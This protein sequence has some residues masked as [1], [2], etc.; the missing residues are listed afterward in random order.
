MIILKLLVP[1]KNKIKITQA[2]VDAL[3]RKYQ[4]QSTRIEALKKLASRTAFELD[5][6]KD[7]VERSKPVFERM[8]GKVRKRN[9]KYRA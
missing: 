2:E 4:D 5:D 3:N 8:I 7:R 9:E 6:M 1:M